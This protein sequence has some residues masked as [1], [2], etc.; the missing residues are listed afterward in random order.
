MRKIMVWGGTHPDEKL[1]ME[2]V[3]SLTADPIP[4]I[5]VG[6]VNE[7]ARQQGRRLLT[8][9]MNAAYPG[10]LNSSV[11]EHRRAAEVIQQSAGFDTVIDLHSRR[12]FGID[13]ACIGPHGVSPRALGWLRTLGIRTL[14]LTTF[15]CLDAHLDNCFTVDLTTNG[16]NARLDTL[17]SALSRFV[18]GD[19]PPARAADFNWCA[20][21]GDIHQNQAMPEDVVAPAAIFE[22]LPD[23]LLDRLGRS[24]EALYWFDYLPK[25]NEAGYWAELC[26][27]IEPPDTSHWPGHTASVAKSL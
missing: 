15:N 22:P 3:D 19:I 13:V 26:T 21:D 16:S 8:I 14:A 18:D 5:S 12:G 20:F 1:P 11:Y 24:G 7:A 25:P 6:I 17:R 4:G 10:D 9:N 23:E 27:L 2:V